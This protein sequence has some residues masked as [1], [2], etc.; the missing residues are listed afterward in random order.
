MLEKNSAV[1]LVMHGDVTFEKAIY[2]IHF[3]LCANYLDLQSSDCWVGATVVGIFQLK[4]QHQLGISRIKP[5][6]ENVTN[7][8]EQNASST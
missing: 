7:I 5:D 8:S 1:L 2:D 4:S 3:C 6:R